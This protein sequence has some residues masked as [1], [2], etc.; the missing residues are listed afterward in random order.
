MTKATGFVPLMSSSTG[1]TAACADVGMPLQ[2][3]LDVGRIDVLAAGD[4]HVVGAADEIVK[5]VLVAAEH[6]AGDVE[7][8]AR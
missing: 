5:A 6:V 3:A 2:H 8:V 1:T 4:E 7:A